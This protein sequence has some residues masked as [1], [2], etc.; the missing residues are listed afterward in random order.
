[1]EKFSFDE[2]RQLEHFLEN[3][4][5]QTYFLNFDGELGKTNELGHSHGPGVQKK[6][7]ELLSKEYTIGYEKTKNG[8]VAKRSFSDHIIKGFFNN[9]KFSTCVDGSPNLVSMKRMLGHVCGNS[10]DVYY[11]TTI[12]YNRETQRITVS[13]VNILQ[14]VDCL[15]FNY[16]PG[17]MMIQQD[18]FAKAL[19]DY[20]DG[21]RETK[22][23]QQI[24]SEL[25]KL[26]ESGAD[27]H[28]K[29]RIKQ[30]EET[31]AKYK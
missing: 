17:Q 21:R 24:K 2:E 6:V 30:K 25:L 23:H 12:H 15:R 20:L 9:V 26:F 16:G 7:G 31:L 8:N 18:L 3:K 5:N 1:M 28:I 29:L 19:R 14:F 13:F 10:N 22:S 27:K 4:L 11:V